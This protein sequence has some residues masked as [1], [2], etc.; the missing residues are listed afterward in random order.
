MKALRKRN[1]LLF[2]LTLFLSFTVVSFFAY[3]MTNSFDATGAIAS[4]GLLAVICLVLII[5]R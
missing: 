2:D 3:M 1:A 5:S 4:L